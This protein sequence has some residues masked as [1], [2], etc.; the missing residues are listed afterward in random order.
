MCSPSP[1]RQPADHSCVQ[2]THAQMPDASRD[3]VGIGI[4]HQHSCSRPQ[5]V[6]RCCDMVPC[7]GMPLLQGT[8]TGDKA[9]AHQGCHGGRDVM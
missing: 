5:A 6:S 3:A 2:S 9:A 4:T 1:P 7:T 8:R